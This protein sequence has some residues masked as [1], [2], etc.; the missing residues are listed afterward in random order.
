MF[1]GLIV[2]V[3]GVVFLLGNLGIINGEAWPI[4]WPCLLI[5]FGLSVIF[6]RKKRN[7]KWEKFGEGM[8]KFGEGI[9]KTFGGN[10]GKEKE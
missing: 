8:K 9:G 6:K 7:E 1:F 2:L 3:I 5:V 10:N 4:I